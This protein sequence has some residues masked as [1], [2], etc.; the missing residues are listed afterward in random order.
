MENDS[1]D[2][3]HPGEL[4]NPDFSEHADKIALIEQEISEVYELLSNR[5]YT[6]SDFIGA[7]PVTLTNSSLHDIVRERNDFLICEKTDGVRYILIIL[8]NGQ[9]YL[10]GRQMGS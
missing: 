9:C 10:T 6:S 5:I 3:L 4:L 2:L 7:H 1:S 8:S